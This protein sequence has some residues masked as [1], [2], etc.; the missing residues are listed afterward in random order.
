MALSHPW[1]IAIFAFAL[2]PFPL[3]L[4]SAPAPNAQTNASNDALMKYAGRWESKCQDGRTFVVVD[5]RPDGNE[6]NG[7][8][9]IGN[10]HGDDEGACMLVTAPPVPE[11]A[12]KI[13]Q[14][15]LHNGVLD[16][17]AS[18]ATSGKPLHFEFK[19]SGQ[20]KADLKLLGTPVEQ[21]PWP[22]EKVRQTN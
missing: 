6:I 9:S 11:H 14:A 10:M 3:H 15:S 2:S 17:T 18:Q 20:D 12:L 5:L 4:S 7:S 16:F 13:G 19:Q 21:H 22:L 1:I 8:V